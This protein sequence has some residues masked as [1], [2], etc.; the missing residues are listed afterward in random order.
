[1]GEALK[2]YDEQVVSDIE[3]GFYLDVCNASSLLMRLEMFNVDIGDRWVRLADV[4]REHLDDRDLIFVSLHYL[5]PLI[6]TRDRIGTEAMMENLLS[7]SKQDD[8]QGRVTAGV[9]LTLA[10]GLQQAGRGNYGEACEKLLSTKYT[11]DP[12]GGS[13]AQR[14]L[15]SMFTIDI[16]SKAGNDFEARG[17]LAERVASRPD[18]SWARQGYADVLTRLG[19]LEKG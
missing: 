4:A 3:S 8:T 11:R 9:G 7:W 13:I 17:L 19:S 5:M 18:S 6:A 14:D 10:K 16:A 12:V 1:M 2:I 15:F